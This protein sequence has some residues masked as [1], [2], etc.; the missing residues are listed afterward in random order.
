[1]N[2][3]LI[4]AKLDDVEKIKGQLEKDLTQLGKDI[5]LNISKIEITD[6]DKITNQ[7][8]NEINKISKQIDFKFNSEGIIQDFNSKIKNGL[9]N[10]IKVNTDFG[11]LKKVSNDFDD[12]LLKAKQGAI[13]FELLNGQLAKMNTVLDKNNNVKSTTLTYQ[14]DSAKQAIEQYGWKAKEVNGEI[15]QS[16]ELIST[17]IVDNKVKL[18]NEMI[19]QDKYLTNLENKLAKI[20]ELSL[21]KNRENENYDNTK[22]LETIANLQEKINELKSKDV[23]ISQ[24]ERNV[25][26]QTITEL[27]NLVKSESSYAEEINKTTK[28]LENQIKTLENLKTKVQERGDN[29]PQEQHR[30]V[31]ELNLQIEKYQELISKN[32]ILGN[33][34]KSRIEK[35]TNSMRMQTHELTKYENTFSNIIGKIKD[36]AIGGSIIYG[37]IAAAKEGFNDILEV[38]TAMR[39]LK[40]VSDE[41]TQAYKEFEEQAN[42]TAIAIGSSTKDFIQSA[43]DWRQ[44]GESFKDSKLLAKNSTIFQNVGDMSQQEATKTLI[45]VMKSFNMTASDSM[46]IM[47]KI[48]Q[49]SNKFSISAQG[50]SEALTRGG[51]SLSAANNDLD[52]T[53]ALITAANSAIQDQYKVVLSRNA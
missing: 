28:F 15:V 9:D 27:E 1:M 50:I 10:N 4:G 18:E 51:S 3:I 37:G 5:S 17:K 34:E 19:A 42:K 16:F 44:A 11:D 12:I 26:S 21:K 45:S 52:Q 38:D 49:E 24:E 20:Q 31:E 39:D 43:A 47:D 7:I 33:V 8:Q 23:K 14:I 32:E 13:E 41:T 46:T 30:I 2:N 29:N 53:I 6:T 35:T 25:L 48:N 40:K 36:Y 22:D